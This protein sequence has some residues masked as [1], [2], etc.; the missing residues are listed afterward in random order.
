MSFTQA[1]QQWLDG[2][3]PVPESEQRVPIER[4]NVTTVLERMLEELKR[5]ASAPRDGAV[6]SCEIKFLAPTKEHPQGKPQPVVKAYAGSEVPVD[7]AIEAY[8]RAFLMAQQAAMEGWEKTV[9]VLQQR[10]A[11]SAAAA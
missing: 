2:G 4:F 8:G 11:A 7:A 10:R 3:F 1:Y 9:D 5:I 6:S